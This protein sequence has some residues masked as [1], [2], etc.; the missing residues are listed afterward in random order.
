MCETC[1]ERSINK[2]T[3]YALLVSEK[4]E[5]ETPLHPLAQ[6]LVH[7]FVD[8]LPSDPPLGL[9]LIRGV[10]HDINLLPGA[11]IPSKA[12]YTC[13][14]I[15]TKSSIIKFRNLLIKVT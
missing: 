3:I 10:E 12:A 13:D 1:M 9:T 2:G 5:G 6:P 11:S 4:G 8:V 7:E 15:G 14:P